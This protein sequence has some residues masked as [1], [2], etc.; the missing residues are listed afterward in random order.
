MR[1]NR[2]SLDFSPIQRGT[3][4]CAHVDSESREKCTNLVSINSFTQKP[5]GYCVAH[6]ANRQVNRTR[7]QSRRKREKIARMKGL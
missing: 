1:W 5:T 6:M 4:E 3:A 2:G 7:E